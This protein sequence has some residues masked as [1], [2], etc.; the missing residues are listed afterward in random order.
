[1]IKDFSCNNINKKS[2]RGIKKKR[3]TTAPQPLLVPISIGRGVYIALTT[4]HLNES[5]KH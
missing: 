2:K 4:L 3:A 5:I 1:M